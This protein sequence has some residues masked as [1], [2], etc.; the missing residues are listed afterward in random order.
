VNYRLRASR[1]YLPVLLLVLIVSGCAQR[2]SDSP[3]LVAEESLDPTAAPTVT[4]VAPTPIP[5]PEPAEIDNDRDAVRMAQNSVVRIETDMGGG[6]GFAIHNLDQELVVVT[7][8]HVV[9]TATA[10]HVIDSSDE[11]WPVVGYYED[12][13]ADLAILEVPSLEVP[14]LAVAANAPDVA[15][16]VWVIGFPLLLAGD[17]TITRGVVSSTRQF[18]N[19]SHLQID[20]AIN[21][22]NSGGP[23]LNES[24][25]LVAVATWK[26][27]R[28]QNDVVENM[29]FALP[30]SRVVSLLHTVTT[31]T[32]Q[33]FPATGGADQQPSSP[34]DRSPSPE[35]NLATEIHS[36]LTEL[37]GSS[38]AVVQVADGSIIEKDSK[39]RVPA[40][41]LIKLWI[42][43]AVLDE[44]YRGNLD[45]QS[46]HTIRQTDQASGTGT[47]NDAAFLG[48]SITYQDLIEYML[49]FSDNTAANILID[50]IGGFDR[51]NRYARESGYSST[52]IQ[53]Y[54]GH[55]DPNS[56]NYTSAAD[57][58]RFLSNLL[59]G[60]VVTGDASADLIDILDYRTNLDSEQLD[61]FGRNLPNTAHYAHISGLIPQTRNEIGFVLTESGQLLI[62]VL[63]LQHLSD[64]AAG[65]QAILSTVER[66]YYLVE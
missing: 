65:E 21:R 56:E 41:S 2:A 18:D 25:E 31:Q 49:I 39:Q 66:I 12:P 33:R 13:I 24:G 46:T 27:T 11:R 8:A 47:L 32:A 61:Y 63:L 48:Q 26:M 59:M 3:D 55:L 57:S 34:D 60:E 30:T 51:V 22:G 23:V 1:L 64:E 62:I 17:P 9:S 50:R 15:D 37:P 45:L 14:P 35:S 7:N 38:S 29:G 58:F 20:A 6:T 10:V 36:L 16:E 28:T 40:G 4:S 52:T 5:T 43:A 54:L 53:R 44:W 19:V 42:A